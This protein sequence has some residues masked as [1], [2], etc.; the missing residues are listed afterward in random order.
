MSTA[1]QL[2]TLSITLSHPIQRHQIARWR[3][4]FLEMI[5]WEDELFHNHRNE[6][7]QGAGTYSSIR[8]QS[9]ARHY[10]Y[11]L[12]QYY[13]QDGRGTI[14]GINEG[15]TA[16]LKIQEEKELKIRWDGRVIALRVVDVQASEHQFRML[17]RPRTY[18][19]HQWMALTQKNHQIW[20]QAKNLHS[21]I[22]LLEKL[23]P[24]HLIALFKTFQWNWPS[25]IE[26][27]LQFLHCMKPL[28]FK[29]QK[30]HTFDV[31]FTANV[32][33][34]NGIAIGKGTSQGFGWLE[35]V[36]EK[37]KGANNRQGRSIGR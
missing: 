37:E 8:A 35:T 5:G 29:G 28:S 7:Y 9:K 27:Q 15:R 26:T 6:G 3:G 33:L 23:L 12:I 31:E 1:P 17:D 4:A 34:P 24:N 30:M 14:L 10:R 13:E 2:K 32:D 36:Q 11:P 16:L 20:E 19:L 21:R 18:R 22:L 25:R